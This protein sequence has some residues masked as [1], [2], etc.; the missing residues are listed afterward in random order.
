MNFTS[1]RFS[2]ILNI[3]LPYFLAFSTSQSGYDLVGSKTRI[4]NAIRAQPS[5][6]QRHWH[7]LRTLFTFIKIKIFDFLVISRVIGEGVKYIWKNSSCDTLR[8]WFLFK[9]MKVSL[10]PRN[11][12]RKSDIL[13][14]TYGFI[15]LLIQDFAF[16]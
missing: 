13:A 5:K 11:Y 4:V 3:L 16:H 6:K 9:P 7:L 15:D 10:S 14:Q 8:S 2:I 1:S 12:S